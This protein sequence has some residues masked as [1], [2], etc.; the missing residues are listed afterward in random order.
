MTVALTLVVLGMLTPYVLLR[1]NGRLPTSTVI[2]AHLAAL[3]IVWIGIVDVVVGAAGLTHRLVEFCELAL[4]D[5][6][7]GGDA[8]SL[9]LVTVAVATT[10]GRAVRVWWRTVRATRRARRRL[11]CAATRTEHDV[12]FTRLGSVACTVGL[13]RP[14]IFVDATLFP[15]LTKPQRAA[16][17]A[18]ERGHVR[19]RHGMIDLAARC[20]AAGLAPWPGAQLAH[21][22]TRRYLEAVAD[23]RAAA[24]TNRRTVAAAIVTAATMP[25]LPA[26]GAAGWSSWRVDRLLDPPPRHRPLVGAAAILIL[27]AIVV[28]AQ[29]VG[30]LL[31]GV[32]LLPLAFPA[33]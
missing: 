33:L 23:D 4:R 13:L 7:T 25:P 24:K 30:H 27:L 26:L 17:L 16:I 32:H 9:L 12:I 18:H 14:R 8:R 1:V 31:A 10:G 21:A 19:G 11:L 5:P 28:F 2:A 29:T 15:A 3:L 6:P 20:M 22:E